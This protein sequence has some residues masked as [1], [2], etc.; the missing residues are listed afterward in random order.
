VYNCSQECSI[1]S[2]RRNDA[3]IMSDKKFANLPDAFRKKL[4]DDCDR[5]ACDDIV[6][7]LKAATSLAQSKGLATPGAALE[8][9]PN[10]PQLGS[11][12]WTLLHSM[13]GCSISSYLVNF[14]HS[15][16]SQREM[17]IG[18]VVPRKSID[19]G[20]NTNGQFLFRYRSI[21]S[22]HVVCQRL[23][24]KFEKETSRSEIEGGPMYLA[25]R[26]AQSCQCEAR[27]AHF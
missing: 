2:I 9:P 12:S 13:V 21:L 25:M 8:C 7:G 22:V 11:S 27:K 19:G 3:L 16:L 1:S 15:S 18:C 26:S 17:P 5:P 4:L 14:P 20:P 6:A 24:R 10:S 23:H